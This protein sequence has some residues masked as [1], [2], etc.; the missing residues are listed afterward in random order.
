VFPSL[1][2]FTF[3]LLWPW[4]VTK[5]TQKFW[6]LFSGQ[7]MPDDRVSRLRKELAAVTR[8]MKDVTNTI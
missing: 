2:A 3:W 4:I 5:Y 6:L 8:D 7:V 1:W